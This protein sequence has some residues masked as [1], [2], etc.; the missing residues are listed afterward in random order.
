M[1]TPSYNIDY[2]PVGM[3]KNTDVFY[4]LPPAAVGMNKEKWLGKSFPVS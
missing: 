4:A 3:V 1:L 2:G